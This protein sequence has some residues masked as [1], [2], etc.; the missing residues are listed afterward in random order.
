[1]IP[2]QAKRV[3]FGD[4]TWKGGKADIDA[5]IDRLIAEGRKA[6]ALMIHGVGRDSGA[7]RP[8]KDAA[9]FERFLQSLKAREAAGDI[10]VVPYMELAELV[11][12]VR[13][14]AQRC[15]AHDARCATDR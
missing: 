4:G 5:H 11:A 1:M 12:P 8:F 14:D 2:M 13:G 3:N 10:I 7:H 6:D 9:H 15:D